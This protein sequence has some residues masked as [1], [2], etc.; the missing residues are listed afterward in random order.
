MKPKFSSAYF[1]MDREGQTCF[2][3]GLPLRQCQNPT[4]SEPIFKNEKVGSHLLTSVEQQQAFIKFQGTDDS[5]FLTIFC[6]GET[7]EQ[8]LDAISLLL[9]QRI[10]QTPSWDN[11]RC[12]TAQD[13]PPRDTDDIRDLFVLIGVHETDQDIC[14]WVRMWARAPLGV[15][16]WISLTAQKPIEWYRDKLGIKPDFLFSLRG[17]GRVSG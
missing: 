8:S 15:P 2:K 9:R 16:L 11:F 7:D 6:S 10:K 4:P 3:N 1:K 14:R 17:S 13:Y 12:V 5:P